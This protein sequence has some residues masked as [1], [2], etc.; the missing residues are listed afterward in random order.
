MCRRVSAEQSCP[1]PHAQTKGKAA[2]PQEWDQGWRKMV[3][4]SPELEASFMGHIW[5]LDSDEDRVKP[6]ST[7]CTSLW[8]APLSEALP[9]GPPGSQFALVSGLES[10]VGIRVSISIW[11]FILP[12]QAPMCTDPR[13]SEQQD[14]TPSWISGLPFCNR[15]R[16]LL[17]HPILSPAL[18]LSA[19]AGLFILNTPPHTY[20]WTLGRGSLESVVGFRDSFC[21][22]TAHTRVPGGESSCWRA[23]APGHSASSLASWKMPSLWGTLPQPVLSSHV[24]RSMIPANYSI[25]P[26][27]GQAWHF[28]VENSQLSPCVEGSCVEQCSS[29]LR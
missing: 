4:R 16:G 23:W 14:S 6:V 22:S 24:P 8:G 21:M 28:P 26:R 20:N 5:A 9:P 2:R 11:Y 29:R 3:S 25:F 7:S 19:G 10:W 17:T 1:G 12:L 27:A 18:D 15:V 13:E